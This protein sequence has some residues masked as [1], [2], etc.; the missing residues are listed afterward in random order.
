MKKLSAI[1][2]AVVAI[3]FAA[4][5]PVENTVTITVSATVDESE[6]VDIESPESYV[7][8]FSNF[9]TGQS[10]T[11]NTENGVAV[12]EGI[13]P[14]IYSVT[15]TAETSAGGYV[16]VITG[17]AS[18]VSFLADGDGTT[19]KVKAAKESALVFKEI[20]YA[21]CRITEDV[22]PG[23][24][25]TYFRD[26]FYEIYN[27]SDATVYADGLCI[28][29][30]IFASYDFATIYTWNIENQDDY[31]FAQYIWQMPGSGTD[32]PIAPGE[33][34]VVAQ[35]ATN[36]KAD[37]LSE[38]K[39]PVDLTGAEFEAIE[40]EK[41]LWNGITI[42]DG[43]AL[44]M[45]KTVNA[46]GYDIPQWLT[47]VG[48]SR[49]VLFKP[50]VPLRSDN[51]IAAENAS[52]STPAHEILITD[53]FD[54]VE[55]V[56][57]ESRLST[58]GLPTILDAG[59]IWCSSDYSGESIIRKVKETKEDGRIV[60]QDTNNTTNDFEVKTDPKVRRNN[61][62]VPTWNTWAE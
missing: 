29:E 45:K 53:I 47:S 33:S 10:V 38:G 28:A 43:P 58:L 3:V 61:E 22:E 40:G 9:A 31:V 20:Y 56:S 35:W 48:G 59:A 12:A 49:Y 25:V 60:Y 4:C 5:D 39:S 54:A 51:F 23:D 13:V 62:G 2:F 30:T 55:A 37:N 16:Y 52:Y 15:A 42:T 41:T 32:Y 19:V 24:G 7:V 46:T 57:D 11:A 26:Q 34:I 14:G 1:I 18:D 50:S 44:N 21:G 6:L 17:T 27:N 36:H 8:T